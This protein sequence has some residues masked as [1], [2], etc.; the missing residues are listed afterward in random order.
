V[1]RSALPFVLVLAL[2]S[3]VVTP[4]AAA[5][6]PTCDPTSWTSYGYDNQLGNAIQTKRLT[7][8]AV[9]RLQ[10][11]WSAE[12]DGPIFAQPLAAEVAGRLP[13]FAATEGGTV[14]AVSAAT[15][16]IVWQRR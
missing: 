5:S 14:Y 3:L 15:G 7:Q 2:A 9:E 13:V 8:S 4:S 11:S 1:R 10:L 6:E 16:Q 12:L